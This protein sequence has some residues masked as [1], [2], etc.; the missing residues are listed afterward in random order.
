VLHAAIKCAILVSTTG[1]D[2]FAILD[3]SILP[4]AQVVGEEAGGRMSLYS[5]WAQKERPE[6]LRIAATLLAGVIFLILIPYFIIVVCPSWD[7]RLGLPSLDFGA[8]NYLLGGLLV[9]V[10]LFFGLWSNLAQITRGRGTPLPILPTQ[11]LL[12]SGP[13]R[14][15]R[16]PMTLGAILAYLGIGIIAGTAV[17]IG[18]VICFT[19]LLILYLKQLEEKELAERFGD[20]Y[21][22]YRREVPFIVPRSPKR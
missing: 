20:A 1:Q 17:G 10:G 8:L 16:N 19:A 18:F 12:T 15:C 3:G 11:E 6:S 5:K 21:L 22:Q 9:V 4:A 13:Y 7:Q 14:Y 2:S